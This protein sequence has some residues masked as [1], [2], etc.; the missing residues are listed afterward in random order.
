VW[1][2]FLLESV[3]WRLVRSSL[4]FRDRVQPSYDLIEAPKI[5]NGNSD[6]NR[7]SP[8][9]LN[10]ALEHGTIKGVVNFNVA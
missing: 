5:S 1:I 6:G 2:Q 4:L 9:L 10:E 7:R 8:A 3:A